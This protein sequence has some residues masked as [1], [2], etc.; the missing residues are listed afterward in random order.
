M[1]FFVGPMSFAEKMVLCVFG[2][3]LTIN[4]SFLNLIIEK[5]ILFCKELMKLTSCVIN[6]NNTVVDN[7]MDDKKYLR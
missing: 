5:F 3:C 6:I 7:T 4:F 1:D 2:V